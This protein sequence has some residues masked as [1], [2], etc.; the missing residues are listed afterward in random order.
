M[1][2]LIRGAMVSFLAVGLFACRKSPTEPEP[3][4]HLLVFRDQRAEFESAVRELGVRAL[5]DF[6]DVDAR[7]VTD[8][9]EGRTP[10]DGR[11]YATRG[12]VLSNP[13][14]VSLFLAPGGLPWNPTNSLSVGRFPFDPL[15]REVEAPFIEDDDLVITFEPG[16]AAAAFAVIDKGFS[17]G[18]D[19]IQFLD[20]EGQLIQ[21]VTFPQAFIGVVSPVRPIAR[22]TI[23]ETADDFD[24]VAY[25]EFVCVR[26]G[27]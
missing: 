2:L 19:L 7:P 5:I 24:D 4:P 11:H 21:R 14:S 23:S 22:I 6:D 16:C 10:F 9:I 18:D 20:P 3:V 17:L 15:P 8:T 1:R 25:D 13:N 27:R 12:I 26:A